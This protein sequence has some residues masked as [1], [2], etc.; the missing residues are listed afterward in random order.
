MAAATPSTLSSGRQPSVG[1]TKPGA[2][3]SPKPAA[4]ELEV[5][6]RNGA[7]LVIAPVVIRNQ[8][9][10]FVVDTGAE[11]TLI[12]QGYVK[13]LGLQRSKK[14]PIPVSGIGGSSVAYLATISD[15]TIGRAHLPA[16]TITVSNLKFGAGL[17][18][19]LGSDVLSTFGK[20]TIDY[21]NEK[22]TLG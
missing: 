12:D 10:A 2:S 18:G 19:L 11:T 4:I 15:W 21:A 17:I 14:A 16:S 6:K 9:Y 8:T 22:A 20:V 3:P 13:K 1:P 7:T 5:I